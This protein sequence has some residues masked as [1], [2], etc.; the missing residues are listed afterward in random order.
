MTENKLQ[1]GRAFRQ[2]TLMAFG[3]AAS[4]AAVLPECHAQIQSVPVQGGFPQNQQ[5]VPY[6]P[7]SPQPAQ[8]PAQMQF[9]PQVAPQQFA[10][11]QFS[12]QQQSLVP[13][14]P[15]QQMMPGQ[16]PMAQVAVQQSVLR[17]TTHQGVHEMASRHP[18][19]ILIG[20]RIASHLIANETR[21][22]GPFQDEIMGARIQ[23]NQRTSTRTRIDFV[24]NPVAIQMNVVL[25]GMTFS[26][27]LSQVRQAAIQ[28]AGSVEFEVA[29]QIEFDGTRLSTRTPS[30]FM[31]VNQQNLG[32]STPM[33]PIP[34]LGPLASSVVMNAAE[35]R[36][37]MTESIAAHRITQ[38]VAPTFNNRLD[39][40]LVKLN[41]L[42]AVDLRNMLTQ[43][44]LYPS[45]IATKSTEEAAMWGVAFE[46]AAPSTANRPNIQQISTGVRKVKALPARQLLEAPSLS[47]PESSPSANL[48]NPFRLT[49]VDLRNQAS[50][51]IHESLIADLAERFE[52]GGKDIQP[53][54]LNSVLGNPATDKPA[55]SVGTLV[56]DVEN[57]IS[58]T[59]TSGEFLI[60]V[61]AGFKPV[62][63]P[64]ISTQEAV[65]AFNPVLTEDHVTL[66][67]ELRTITPANQKEK[68]TGILQMAGEA[69]VRNAIEQKLKEIKLPRVVNLPRSEDQAPL[70]LRL[71][72]LT[73]ADGW[74]T[75]DYEVSGNAVPQFS[76]A[77][78][79]VVDA[80]ATQ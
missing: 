35:Q 20:E 2:L 31:R 75:C 47:G 40:E 62:L 69:M 46:T 12:Q 7:F 70:A 14:Y 51:L 76:D 5:A 6:R 24:D 74:M 64:E 19:C 18:L 67:P 4:A 48:P 43:A 3:I 17:M 57:P 27:T 15:Q 41:K 52:L 65:F 34:L 21:D 33:N 78:E 22:E 9:R 44:Q 61:R 73:L 55:P 36:R 77:S 16:G 13:R 8:Q 45:H 71:K 26:Q 56:L 66:K 32:A 54:L 60:T 68:S 29:K 42:L 25:N 11:G 79:A 53:E 63:G 28:S 49:G 10:P 58:A 59:I 23:G 37:P 72:N 50:M 38:L 39:S 80:P 30:A 1:P